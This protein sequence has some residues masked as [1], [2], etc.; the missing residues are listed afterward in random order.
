M[1]RSHESPAGCPAMT[2]LAAVLN[3]ETNA[4]DPA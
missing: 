3:P 4:T 2:A 1:G